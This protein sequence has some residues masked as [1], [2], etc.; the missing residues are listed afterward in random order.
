MTKKN[1]IYFFL[2][3]WIIFFFT[4]LIS[5]EPR[6]NLDIEA[7]PV[8]ASSNTIQV[9]NPGGTRF[10]LTDSFDVGSKIYYRLR[11]SFDLARRHQ[12]S[13]LFAPLSLSADGEAG[14][15]ILFAETNFPAGETIQ[16][17]YR[18]NSYRLTY[19]YRLVNRDKINLWIGFTAKIRD[20][21]IRLESGTNRAST[22]NIGFVP[23][24]NLVL[25]WNWSKKTGLFLEADALASPG[26]EG[27]AEDV[28][29][30]VWYRIHPNSRLRL[31]YRF[32][33]GGADVEQVYNF[34]FLH[35]FFLAFQI[36][37]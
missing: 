22:T 14:Q 34:A 15:D 20:A 24:L 3:L 5:E 28:A 2:S 36:S 30:S 8:F 33:E 16:A 23:L 18:F 11:L 37:F 1:N 17:L 21:E 27:R 12:I 32:V 7:G 25:D 10:S 26:G 13:L 19:R 6:W 9:P 4:P 31:G 35:Y 29:V